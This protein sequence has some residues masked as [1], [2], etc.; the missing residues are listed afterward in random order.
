MRSSRC[1]PR[2]D[3]AILT[4]LAILKTGAAYLPIDPTTPRPYRVHAHRHHPTAIITTTELTTHLPPAVV[5]VIT[6]DTLTSMT[7]PP[8]HCSHPTPRPGV[9]DLHLRHHRNPKGVAITHHNVTT[10]LTDL[11]LDIA[12]DGVWSQW[13]S[14]S[15]DVAVLEVFGPAPWWA[16]GRGARTSRA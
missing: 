15:F 13:H 14:Y 10:L 3:H 16:A 1:C 9:S 7:T 2:S 4:I 12:I 8:R 11:Q 6:L 5:P